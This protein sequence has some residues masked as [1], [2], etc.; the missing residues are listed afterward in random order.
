MQLNNAFTQVSL[1][2][3]PS[4]SQPEFRLTL[5]N[6]SLVARVANFAAKPWRSQF[7]SFAFRW[8]RLFPFCPLP[9][10][11][12]FGAWWLLR[13]DQIGG[14]L[15]QGAF[16][17]AEHRFVEK[18]LQPGMTVLDIGANQGYYTLLSSRKVKPHGKV[19]AFEPSPREVRR[20]KLH[21]LLNR[22]KNVEVSASAL[23]SASGTGELHILLGKESACNS[24]RPPSVSQPTGLLCV[25]VERLD[26]VMRA[27]GVPRVDFIKLDVEGAELSVLQGAREMLLRSP[28]PAVLVE[29]QDIRTKPWGYRAAEIISYLFELGYQWYLPLSDG[30]LE[31]LP[32]DG[33]NYDGNFVAIPHE[34]EVRAMVRPG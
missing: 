33:E 17:N 9:F 16:E 7:R 26:D 5:N 25:T 18:F 11:L 32:I 6:S 28:R 21:L 23:G 22:C 30:S 20:L 12:P 31:K 8:F 27:R 15:L 34:L 14:T 2:I 4:L 10:R 19:F 1:K 13:N 24:L 29:V 3:S